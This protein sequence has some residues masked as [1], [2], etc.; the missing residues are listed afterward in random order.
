MLK[1][2]S[3]FFPES[4]LTA[5]C[6]S[7]DVLSGSGIL[8]PGATLIPSQVCAPGSCWHAG[9]GCQHSLRWYSNAVT[10]QIG[11]EPTV[12]D[13]VT[14]N[15]LTGDIEECMSYLEDRI[16]EITQSE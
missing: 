10:L 8:F 15:Q 13:L 12:S 4:S 11:L 9:S 7:R 16:M 5:F 6:V 14:K 1:C 3:Y 2:A